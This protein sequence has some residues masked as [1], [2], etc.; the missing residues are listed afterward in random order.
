M[1]TVHA[2]TPERAV[3]QIALLVLQ[4]GTR[5]RRED[6]VHYMRSTIDKRRG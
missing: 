5:L 4:G 1:T 3:A 6:V 2:D